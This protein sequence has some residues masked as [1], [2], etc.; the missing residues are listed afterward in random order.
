MKGILGLMLAERKILKSTN[1]ADRSST[2]SHDRN[3]LVYAKRLHLVYLGTRPTKS[4]NDMQANLEKELVISHVP[5]VEADKDD[6]Y[7]QFQARRNSAMHQ[8]S[9]GAAG[10]LLAH[11]KAWRIASESREPFVLVLEDDAILTAYGKRKLGDL[12]QRFPQYDLNLLHL[13]HPLK[14]P[15]L[16]TPRR[17][18]QLSV[19]VAIKTLYESVLLKFT[20]PKVAKNQFPPS[21]HAYLISKS[22][23]T[24]LY[25]NPLCFT[26]PVD[27]AFSA[28]A[29]VKQHKV[30]RVRTPLFLQSGRPST[31]PERQL[32]KHD[33]KVY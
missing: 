15:F 25:S 13:G 18:R 16:P 4:I 31:F 27:I 23:A 28:L 24:G 9:I 7:L 30:G 26:I 2:N 14:S 5:F 33:N 12:L 32:K 3:A 10:C 6:D 20:Q 22:F 19:D 29:Q 21:A 1:E 17:L 8:I 11:R